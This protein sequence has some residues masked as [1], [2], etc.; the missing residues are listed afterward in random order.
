MAFLTLKAARQAE[1]L[2]DSL[3]EAGADFSF[4]TVLSTERN[5]LRGFSV[6]AGKCDSM[7]NRKPHSEGSRVFEVQEETDLL[8]FLLNCY[9]GK[10]RNYVK[11][12]LSRGQVT[13][14]GNRVTQFDAKLKPGQRVEVLVSAPNRIKLPFPVVYEDEHLIVIDKPAGMLSIST[15]KERE[16]TAYHLLTEY[17][18]GE[19]QGSRIFVVHRLDRETSGLLLFAKNE[20]L[21][22]GLQENWSELVSHRGYLA[23]VEGRV[24]AP[25]GE[26][27]S[28]LKQ[29]KTLLVYSAAKDGDGKEAVTNYRTIQSGEEYSLLDISLE[30]GRKNQI[31]V[32]M[33]DI[34]HPVAGDRKYGAKTDPMKRLGLHAHLLIFHHPHTGESI[35][36]EAAMP[37]AF[38]SIK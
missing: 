12:L 20:R 10:S 17:V 16:R 29:T 23:V 34:G 18:R 33:K 13:I 9:R 32:H 25:N 15:D 19:N 37:H 28:W 36:L 21:K 26:I 3:L 11:A 38:S 4:E 1:A 27:R 31:R 14:D 6:E 24:D 5:L 8:P 30:T 22:L 7:A 35:K 2:R